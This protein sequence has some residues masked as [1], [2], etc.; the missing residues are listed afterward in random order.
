LAREY[1]GRAATVQFISQMIEFFPYDLL[2]IATHC[3]DASGYRWTYEF[4]DSEGMPR[5]LVVDIAIGMGRT[6][7]DDLLNVTQFVNFVSLDG[8]DWHDPE[9]RS[10]VYIGNAIL[11]FTKRTGRNGDLEP[12]KKETVQRVTWSSVL[13]LYDHNFIA[14]P[15]PM[16]GGQ[17]PIVINNA[18]GSW[19]RL[20]GTFTFGNTR[21]YVGAL[22]PIST[23]EAQEVTERLIEREF[24]KPLAAALWS[25]QRRVY[26]DSIRRPY[27][28]TGVYTQW[29]RVSLQDVPAILLR[30]LRRGLGRW[31]AMRDRAEPA[32]NH[33]RELD[34]TVK[35]YE[36]EIL[37][38]SRR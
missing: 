9:K 10:K 31:K 37:H 8:V 23:A 26:G 30:R 19:H 1:R 36:D 5:N 17:T 38:Y 6:S 20:A 21:A 22:F 24:H 12:I 14:L 2:V 15:R 16:A 7:D 28:I 29:L 35:Y 27:L 4:V 13:K 33:K 11:D 34:E 18:C 32:Y 25:A 3:G